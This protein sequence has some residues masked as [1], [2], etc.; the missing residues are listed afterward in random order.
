MRPPPKAMH[1]YWVGFATTG[2]PQAPDYP[3]R[4]AYHPQSDRIMDF[5]SKGPVA[6]PDPWKVWMDLAQTLNDGHEAGR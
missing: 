1:A 4:P 5:T 6:G 3:A 2:V